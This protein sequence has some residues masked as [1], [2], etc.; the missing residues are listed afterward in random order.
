MHIEGNIFF[1]ILPCIKTAVVFMKQSLRVEAYENIR[2]R[3]V[4]FQLKPGDKIF[5]KDIASSLKTS[6]T[7]VREALLMLENEGLVICDNRLGYVVKK[8]TTTEVKEY[9]SLREILELFAAPTVIKSITPTEIKSLEKNLN[10]MEASIKKDDFHNI[11]KCESEFHEILYKSTRSAIFFKTISSLID[12]FQWL[13]GIS[14]KAPGG[15]EDSLAG[16]KAMLKAIKSKD[17]G[18]FKRAIQS[19]ITDAKRHA[20]EQ[21]RNLLEE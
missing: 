15:I 2:D 1:N 14:L 12:K 20:L 7:P 21:G 6:R 17:L 19:H 4:F 8:L 16:Q 18:E 11:V 10:R 13:R 5:E 3:I 9:L